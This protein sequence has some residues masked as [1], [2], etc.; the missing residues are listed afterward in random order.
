MGFSSGPGTT[1]KG[2]CFMSD[3]AAG[4]ENLRPMSRF[5]SKTV[6]ALFMAAW[7]FAASP[8]S[9]SWSLKATK[10]GVVRLPWLFAII[11]TRSFCQTPTQEYVVP[12][13]M[14]MVSPSG[15]PEVDMVVGSR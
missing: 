14:P 2:Q 8:T 1:V 15:M 4:S 12:R 10:E 9:R 11:S 6:F 13:S 5:A 7:F 3:C